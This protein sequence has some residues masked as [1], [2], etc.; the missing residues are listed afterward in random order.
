[1]CKHRRWILH[2]YKSPKTLRKQVRII[3]PNFGTLELWKVL[4]WLSEGIWPTPHRYS[5]LGLFFLLCRY[6]FEHARTVWLIS[7]F[8]GIII[9]LDRK[10]LVNYR[11]YL[12]QHIV[13]DKFCRCYF[14]PRILFHKY[15]H[16]QNIGTSTLLLQFLWFSLVTKLPNQCCLWT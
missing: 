16:L 3:H 14:I 8:Y 13:C 5:L 6:R 11:F 12:F 10:P 4:I 7:D 15:R 9:H 2:Y 1:M